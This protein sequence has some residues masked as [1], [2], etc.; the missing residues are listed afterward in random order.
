MNEKFRLWIT[1]EVHPKFPITLLQ[2]SIKFTN[3]PP[4]GIKAGLKRTYAGITQVWNTLHAILTRKERRGEER[5]GEERRGEERRG[6][7]RRGEARR[8]EAVRKETETREISGLGETK[9]KEKGKGRVVDGKEESGKERQKDKQIKGGKI[10]EWKR[11]IEEEQER[12]M[13]MGNEGKAK[14]N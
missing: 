9:R 2:S 13:E 7:A 6:E 12:V 14:A 3:E 5:R 4:Q 1:T 11:I 8:G 10:I